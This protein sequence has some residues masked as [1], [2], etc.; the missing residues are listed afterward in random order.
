MYIFLL[1]SHILMHAY[2]NP[3]QEI[4]EL[5]FKRVNFNLSWLDTIMITFRDNKA[6]F[7]LKSCAF[8][9][10]SLPNEHNSSISI[11][12]YQKVQSNNK[13]TEEWKKINFIKCS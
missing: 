10:I 6:C 12:F 7:I 9:N 11:F 1:P 3:L 2:S 13:D 8:K 5:Q 4:N